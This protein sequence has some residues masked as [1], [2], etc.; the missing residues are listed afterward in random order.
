MNQCLLLSISISYSYN[1]CKC[2][3]VGPGNKTWNKL[4][5]VNL[6]FC[7]IFLFLCITLRSFGYRV[8]TGY[9]CINPDFPINLSDNEV[10]C[11]CERK[12]W[13]CFLFRFPLGVWEWESERTFPVPFSEKS[14]ALMSSR[15]IMQKG[16]WKLEA[17]KWG[18]YLMFGL[19]PDENI[20]REGRVMLCEQ[21]LGRGNPSDPQVLTLYHPKASR[22]IQAKDPTLTQ[23]HTVSGNTIAGRNRHLLGEVA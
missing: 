18:F 21:S 12:R 15:W 23:Q 8:S 17:G 9:L 22:G 2:K 7:V 6:C 19:P 20:R 10:E 13:Q 16:R 14:S 4:L 11:V 1:I 3:H 5:V